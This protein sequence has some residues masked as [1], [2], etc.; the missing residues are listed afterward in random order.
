M[1]KPPTRLAEVA[2]SEEIAI[3]YA[4]AGADLVEPTVHSGVRCCRAIHAFA[5][6]SAQP[7]RGCS[8]SSTPS[9]ACGA[10]Q[11]GFRLSAVSFGRRVVG[12]VPICCLRSSFLF[13]SLCYLAFRCVAVKR[14]SA[15][16]GLLS[17]RCLSGQPPRVQHAYRLVSRRCFSLRPL[18]TMRSAICRTF[19]S[20]AARC[21]SFGRTFNPKVAGSIPAGPSI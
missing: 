14:G 16:H 13:S 9:R 3:A 1:V 15:G 20:R 4:D 8:R 10:R 12:S 2:M 19:R 11:F 21:S 5:R 18:A 6:G 17:I 7:P